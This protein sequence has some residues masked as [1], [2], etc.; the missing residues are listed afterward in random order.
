[1]RTLLVLLEGRLA[2]AERLIFEARSLGE[3]AQG[4]NAEVS[5]RLQLY[6][7]RWEQGRLAELEG[8]VRA[9]VR[10]YPTYPVW[11]CV[12]APVEAELG[13]MDEAGQLLDTAL[14][15]DEEW[16]VSMGFLAEAAAALQD[17]QRAGVLYEAL[18]PYADRLAVSYP[19][20]CTGSVSRYLGL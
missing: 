14:P 18:L 4:W 6:V 8:V 5:Y 19:E 3:R 11:R 17:A 7:L 12:L 10:Q 1:D 13:R 20:I 2:E 16:L 9:S 15:F